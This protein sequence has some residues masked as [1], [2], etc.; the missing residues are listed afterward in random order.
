MPVISLTAGVQPIGQRILIGDD[1]RNIQAVTISMRN[2]PSGV[3]ANLYLNQTTAQ[4]PSVDVPAGDVLTL[5]VDPTT[6]AFLGFTGV[7]ATNG[8]CYYQL[9]E[10]S[11]SSSS[12]SN[13]VTAFT[14]DYPEGATPFTAI[15]GNN[16]TTGSYFTTFNTPSLSAGQSIYITKFFQN[17]LSRQ[18]YAYSL[19]ISDPLSN[20]IFNT[21]FV[22]GEDVDITFN[23][24]KQI[25]PSVHA[26]V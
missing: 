12:S 18:T 3:T 13:V 24:A 11:L 14:S 16:W 6:I 19:T 1:N 8:A 21:S 25:A 4:G 26:G 10:D 23:P 17:G 20:V 15:L 5:P 2:A 22:L 9:S 7:P